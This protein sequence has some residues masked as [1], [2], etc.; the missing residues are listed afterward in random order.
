MI[1]WKKFSVTALAVLAFG[2]ASAPR[3]NAGTEIVEPYRAPA[4]RYNYAPPPP[5]RPIYYA[6]VPV[7]VF[8]YPGFRRHA[9]RFAVFPH[10]R[11]FG[12]RHH[13]R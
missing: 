1:M 2:F 7:G 10:R 9:P 3:S 8:F 5:P 6:P 4:P 13:W 12:R 11:F